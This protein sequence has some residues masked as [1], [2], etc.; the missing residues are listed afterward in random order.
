MAFFT[1]SATY[2]RTIKDPD[3]GDEATITL[4]PLNA[5]DRAELQ[6]LTRMQMG[7][8]G[9]AEL[10][11][12]Q[13]Q[14][15]TVSRAIVDWT[16]D[17][18]TTPEAVAMLHPDVFDDIYSHISWGSVPVEEPADASPLDDTGEAQ[19]EIHGPPVVLAS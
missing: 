15:I 8:E 3:T 7:D 6:D 19:T 11:L 1:C 5:G 2:K 4:R 18:P 12:G 13:M 16:L 10:R 17:E 14:L 9:S